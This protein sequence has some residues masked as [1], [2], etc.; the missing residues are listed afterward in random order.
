[1]QL[2]AFDLLHVELVHGWLLEPDAEE[3]PLIENKT[4]NQLVNLVIE[5]N[6]A[7]STLQSTKPTEG[8]ISSAHDVLSTKATQ[9]AIVNHFLDRSGHQLTQ[10][11]LDVLHEYLKD[12]Q[13]VVFFRNNHFNTLTKYAGMLY[14]L[15]TDFGYA[16]VSTVVWEKLDVIDGDTEYVNGQFSISSPTKNL[17]GDATL[18]DPQSHADYQLA[19][20][21]SQENSQAPA[22][23]VIGGA[24]LPATRMSQAAPYDAEME[25]A[26]RASIEEYNRLNPHNPIHVSSPQPGANG[27]EGNSLF[28]KQVTLLAERMR[29]AGTTIGTSLQDVASSAANIIQPTGFR[30]PS[31]ATGTPETTAPLP[32]T[33]PYAPITR[34]QSPNLHQA[35]TLLNQPTMVTRGLPSETSSQ[36]HLDAIF[37]MQLQQQEPDQQTVPVSEPWVPP[38]LGPTNSS[39]S[40][41]V[42]KGLRSEKSSQVQQDVILAIPLHVSDRR[43]PPALRPTIDDNQPTS[44][45]TIVHNHPPNVAR[46]LPS[47]KSWQEHQDAILAMQ[48]QQQERDQ[49]TQPISDQRAPPSSRPTIP[50]KHQRSAKKKDCIIS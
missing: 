35:N 26:Q 48:L 36:E 21:L 19:L 25:A 34:G 29:Q 9:G 20:Q 50:G 11:G 47:E 23:R 32:K 38:S 22:A 2:N 42:V 12:G 46:G 8:P 30:S 18:D 6:D 15:V 45:S 37:A 14:L 44:H 49:Q 28:E 39:Q 5:G 7:A 31:K 27:T 16:N 40:T 4:Y 17:H 3:Y 13:I 10:Y 41:T 24:P 1:M 33:T 43:V